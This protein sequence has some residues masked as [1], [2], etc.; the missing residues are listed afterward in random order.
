M[1]ELPSLAD[2][3]VSVK[4]L[5]LAGSGWSMRELLLVVSVRDHLLAATGVS[6]RDLLLAGIG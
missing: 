1:Y 3:G 2:V 6:V 4:D 5:L